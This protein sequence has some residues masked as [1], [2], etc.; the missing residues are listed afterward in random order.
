M[1]TPPIFE[2]TPSLSAGPMIS[3]LSGISTRN[4]KGQPLQLECMGDATA[5][6]KL[7]IYNAS[8]GFEMLKELEYL[9]YRT[10][11]PNIFFNPNF[12]I[13]AIP[14]LEEKPVKLIVMRDEENNKSRLRLLLP[15][16]IERPAFGTTPPVIR[17]WANVFGPNGTPLIDGDDPIG[18]MRDFFSI[19]GRQHLR[20]PPVI[21]FPQVFTDGAAA[22]VIR[23]VALE[24]DLPLQT[25]NREMRAMLESDQDG[26]TYL[27]NAV[28]KAHYREI[29][30]QGRR[31]NEM[32]K[33]RYS[34]ASRPNDIRVATEAF[35]ALEVKGWKGKA[36]TAMLSD[37]L[38][39]AFAR[40]ATHNLAKQGLCRIHTLHL[41]SQ[42]I[43]SLIVF[44]ENGVASTWKI[45]FDEEY[46]RYSPGKLLMSY[47]TEYLLND[48][49]VLHGD[50]CAVP[51]HSLMNHLWSERKEMTSLII[52]LQRNT[53][54][55]V[56]QVASQLDLYNQTRTAAK[57]MRDRMK[58]VL[59][60]KSII[61]FF[62]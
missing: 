38:Q 54:R 28:S 43:A 20:L 23:S 58:S 16:S 35:L 5:P 62:N 42:L 25:A 56:R 46:S 34:V 41:D 36:R 22:R 57:S 19:M 30:R 11:E 3:A 40:E 14:R 55:Q 26:E 4:L 47:A 59:K 51:D 10:I 48:F 61:K 32:G 49:N 6:R 8:T 21:I 50:S 1:V 7:A 44:V 18:V 2:E 24:S 39:A 17:C 31:F 12:L 27:R 29:I 45:T 9:T 53:D 60:N 52:G 33:L 13:P 37:R 15:F